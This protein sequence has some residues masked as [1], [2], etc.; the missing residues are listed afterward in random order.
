MNVPWKSLSLAAALALA[1][2]P[3]LAKPPPGTNPDSPIARWVRSLTDLH[4]IPCCALADCR[5]VHVRQ[6]RDATP[7]GWH[8]Q[9]FI[10]RARFGP[11]APGAW[12]DVPEAIVRGTREN[13]PAPNLT[14]WACYYAG[15]VHCLTL[16]AG[17]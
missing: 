4:D 12:M 3:A 9:A 14:P 1:V 2:A 13:G 15:A 8:W 11:E 7:R 17:F 16:D 6:T 10:D 5:P